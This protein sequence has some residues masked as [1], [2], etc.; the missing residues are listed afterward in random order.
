[1]STNQGSRLIA[2]LRL[3]KQQLEDLNV[4]LQE[5]LELLAD[6][7][8]Y[9]QAIEH[10]QYERTSGGV[11]SAQQPASTGE[12]GQTSA[13]VPSDPNGRRRGT[14]EGSGPCTASTSASAA[15]GAAARAWRKGRTSIPGSVG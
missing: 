5:K 10:E 2:H 3:Q 14:G 4:V 1:M 7:E 12:Q 9:M 15:D 8:E 13:A 11:A 6:E